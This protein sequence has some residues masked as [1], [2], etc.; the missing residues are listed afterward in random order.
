MHIFTASRLSSDNTLFPDR[1]EIDASNV[2]YHKGYVL[3]HKTIVIARNNVASVSL[4]SGIIFFFFF[5]ESTGGKRITASGFK[6]SDA[7]T[8]V[9]L[10]TE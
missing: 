2:T 1:L 7:R 10:L 9:S 8:I 6:K 3:G 4:S 5:I